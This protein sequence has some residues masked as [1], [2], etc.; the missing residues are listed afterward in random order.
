M[1]DEQAREEEKSEFWTH[2]PSPLNKQRKIYNQLP[3]GDA[4]ITLHAR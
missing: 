4:A 3:T 2:T 1:R